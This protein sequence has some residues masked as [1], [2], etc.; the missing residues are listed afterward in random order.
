MS[1][2]SGLVAL[3]LTAFLAVG[4]AVAS[5]NDTPLTA[6]VVDGCTA[7]IVSTTVGATNA[8]DQLGCPNASIGSGV[9]QPYGGDVFYR[10]TVPFSYDLYV[11]VEPL[12][13]W[14]V[15]AYVVASPWNPEETCVVAAD[16][17]GSGFAEQLRFQNANASGGEREYI[18]A[19]DSW[20][21]DQAGEFRLSLTCDF[22]VTNVAPSFGTLKAR[23]GGDRR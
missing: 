1:L 4:A 20:R 6:E 23:F 17:A 13:D 5:A 18:V 9:V 8:F 16:E 21:A 15:S 2:R 7:V 14:D 19:V 12:G 3:G 10:V 11:L 22:A